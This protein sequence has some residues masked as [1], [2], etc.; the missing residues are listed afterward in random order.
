MDVWKVGVK[1]TLEN[2]R[3]GQSARLASLPTVLPFRTLILLTYGVLTLLTPPELSSADDHP[4]N[5]DR[6]FEIMLQTLRPQASDR[7]GT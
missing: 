1:W 3:L 7:S 4:Q 5:Q 2:A 6:G